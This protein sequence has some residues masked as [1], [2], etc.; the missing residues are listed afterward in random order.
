MGITTTGSPQWSH[1]VITYQYDNYPVELN[2]RFTK[3]CKY[4]H[5]SKCTMRLQVLRVMKLLMHMIF[6]MV[7]VYDSSRR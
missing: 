7:E 5:N 1:Y 6:A 3:I 4:V 2:A